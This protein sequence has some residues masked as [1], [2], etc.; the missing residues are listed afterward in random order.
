MDL[1]E[2]ELVDQ[3]DSVPRGNETQLLAVSI[4][5]AEMELCTIM[6]TMTCFLGV[7]CIYTQREFLK[8]IFLESQIPYNCRKRVAPP[9]VTYSGD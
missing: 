2:V 4:I 9:T 8:C 1:T 3:Y 7:L 5:L 6:T